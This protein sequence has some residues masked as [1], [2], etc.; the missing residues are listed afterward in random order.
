MS[1]IV[2]IGHSLV[3]MT[4][5]C[6]SALTVMNRGMIRCGGGVGRI[7]VRNRLAPSAVYE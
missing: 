3:V 1:L 4:G 6:T 2:G 5:G 7:V